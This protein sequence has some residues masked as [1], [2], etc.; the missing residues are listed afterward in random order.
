MPSSQRRC[1][2]LAD[3]LTRLDRSQSWLRL[4]AGL[5]D[6]PD[7]TWWRCSTMLAQPA[8]FDK[9]GAE[10]AGW[11]QTS[12]AEAPERVVAGYLLTWYLSVPGLLAGLLFHRERR[13]PELRPEA[14]ALRLGEPRP[15]P[16]AVALLDERFACLPG[17]PDAASPAATVVA[18][19]SALA[20]LLR[21]RFAGH[22]ARFVAAFGPGARF[23]RRT[24]WAAATDALDEGL[25]LAGRYCGTET[26]GVADAALV[27]PDLAA[28]ELTPFTS[29]S[30]LVA[31]SEGWTRRRESCCFH[32][33]LRNGQGE[34]ETC[35][36]VRDKAVIPAPA[37]RREQG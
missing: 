3:S 23:G 22:A 29:P 13:V 32:Y 9:W 31:A 30:T 11:L 16:D 36:R 2:A 6:D 37:K 12:Y 17:D 33:A 18:D 20:A 7:R 4:H 15:H 27:L 34:C 10:L 21:A 28:A 14:L 24:L 26:N 1:G 35:P 8:H 19:E 5:P 25:W